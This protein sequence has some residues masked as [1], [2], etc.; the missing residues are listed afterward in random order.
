MALFA[1]TLNKIFHHSCLKYRRI[2][3]YQTNRLYIIT[4]VTVTCARV[5][6]SEIVRINGKNF[7]SSKRH[8]TSL[9]INHVL[10]KK[11]RNNI[12]AQ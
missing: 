6:S 8:R 2:A 5:L 3:L 12:Y 1:E 4:Y 11:S 9:S 7:N 10:G